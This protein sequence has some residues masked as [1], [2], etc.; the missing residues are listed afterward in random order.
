MF[1]EGLAWR[2]L[3]VGGV[4]NENCLLI[5]SFR[6]S[7]AKHGDQVLIAKIVIGFTKPLYVVS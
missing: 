2:G 6:P 4:T 7:N 1:R 5:L 3:G